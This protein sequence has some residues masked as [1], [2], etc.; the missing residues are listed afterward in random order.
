MANENITMDSGGDLARAVNDVLLAFGMQADTVLTDSI[1][2]CGKEAVKRLKAESEAHGWKNYAKNWKYQKKDTKNAKQGTVYN[3][4]YGSLTH[5]LENGHEKVLWGKST[6]ERVA[7][8]PHIAPVND[9]VA[10]ELPKA[11]EKGLSQ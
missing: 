1:D 2:K 5:L 4:K 9:W 6:G 10:E 7:G 8:H 3:A 11:I